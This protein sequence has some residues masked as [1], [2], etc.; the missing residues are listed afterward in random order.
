LFIGSYNSN[1]PKKAIIKEHADGTKMYIQ[2]VV[3]G[4]VSCGR[5]WLK[6]R[7]KKLQEKKPGDNNDL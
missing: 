7:M 3:G 5:K 1:A 4:E 2:G 6:N